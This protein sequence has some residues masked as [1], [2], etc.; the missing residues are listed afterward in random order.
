MTR[1]ISESLKTLNRLAEYFQ[2]NPESLQVAERVRKEI[3][4]FQLHMPLISALRNPGLTDRHWEKLTQET[5]VYFKPGADLTLASFFK[6]YNLSPHLKAIERIS[7]VAAKEHMLEQ[8]LSSMESRWEELELPLQ[9]YNTD[10]FII[11]SATEVTSLL[12]SQ[13]LQCQVMRSSPHVRPHLEALRGWEGWLKGVSEILEEWLVCQDAWLYLVP[14]FSLD[15]TIAELPKQSHKF[16]AADKRWRR[17]MQMACDSRRVIAIVGQSR[18]L[19]HLR[20]CNEE[21]QTAL[22]GLYKYLDRKRSV[23]P[24]YFLLSNEDV[25]AVLS[26]DERKLLRLLPRLFPG[27]HRV[28][29]SPPAAGDEPALPAPSTDDT[30]LQPEST[31]HGIITSSSSHLIFSRPVVVGKIVESWLVALE[32]SMGA[33]L[34]GAVQRS[35]LALTEHAWQDWLARFPA[36]VIRAVDRVMFCSAVEAALRR[37]RGSDMEQLDFQLAAQ[38]EKLIALVRGEPLAVAAASAAAEGALAEQRADCAASYAEP[39]AAAAQAPPPASLRALASALLVRRAHDRD[40]VARLVAEG[41]LDK[42]SFEWSMQ[43]RSYYEG[44]RG[45]GTLRLRQLAGVFDYGLE[46]TDASS[47]AVITPPTERAYLS[48]T[49]ALQQHYGVALLGAGDVGKSATLSALAAV[50]A[51]PT[52]QLNVASGMAAEDIARFLRGAMCSGAW[53]VLHRLRCLPARMLSVVAQQLSTVRRAALQG[54]TFVFEGVDTQPLDGAAFFITGGPTLFHSQLP[55]NNSLRSTFRAIALLPP[56]PLVVV[57]LLMHA[58]GFQDAAASALKLV[59]LHEVAAVSPM[60]TSPTASSASASPF[61]LRSMRRVL[62]LA[63]R[64]RDEDGG[65][66]D[67]VDDSTL[68]VTALLHL[69]RPHMSQTD[70]QQLRML[71]EDFF[72]DSRAAPLPQPELRAAVQKAM[73]DGNY[74]DAPL[75]VER[76]LQMAEALGHARGI[77]LVGPAA[78]G[79]TTAWQLL[80]S[81]LP[82]TISTEVL[83]PSSSAHARLMGAHDGDTWRDGLLVRVL[84]RVIA[85]INGDAATGSGAAA[86]AAAP[87][88]SAPSPPTPPPPLP[89]SPLLPPLPLPSEAEGR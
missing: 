42:S 52:A 36:Q 34:R 80:Q 33:A 41:T 23:F 46:L 67:S 61:G 32:E 27:V 50:L 73:A 84:R 51:V 1:T 45:G 53:A 68:L 22:R 72:P 40:V 86:I 69:H 49:S 2:E 79:K 19:D 89:L 6:F 39:A 71:I 20:A 55:L 28:L 8:E 70:L 9:A 3:M 24:R 7:A 35:V 83:N 82:T 14:L 85:Y 13:L 66:G 74:A 63:T 15:R 37:H 12:E 11:A 56:E 10:T 75:L 4:S 76:V 25:I 21:L 48:I 31:L 60:A 17:I 88:S 77:A 78:S 43:L 64:L 30:L 57:R 59:R 29:V 65:L 26:G 38:V 54:G 62:K 18:L 47:P 58:A 16:L 81:A 87:A 44:R 5:G